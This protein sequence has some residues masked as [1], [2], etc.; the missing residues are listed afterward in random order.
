M[1]LYNENRKTVTKEIVTFDRAYRVTFDYP[2][3]K[4]PS[5]RFDEETIERTDGNDRSL[6]VKGF[7][8]KQFT[9]NNAATEFNLLDNT[10]G[11]VTGTATYQDVFNILYSLYFH[12]AT[13]RDQK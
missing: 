9:P 6:G 4:T 13:E 7:L 5:V 1:P 10:T 8:N 2:N 3:K 11:E 12:L